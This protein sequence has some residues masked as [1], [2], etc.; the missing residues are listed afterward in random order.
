MIDFTA[1]IAIDFVWCRILSCVVFMVS[2]NFLKV[3]KSNSSGNLGFLCS[4]FCLKKSFFSLS[5]GAYNYVYSH[6]SQQKGMMKNRV[7]MDMLELSIKSSFIQPCTVICLFS[8]P[9]VLKVAV[10]PPFQFPKLPWCPFETCKF[11]V[12]PWIFKKIISYCQS[13][14]LKTACPFKSLI[15]GL[16]TLILSFKD[17]LLM[18]FQYN[19]VSSLV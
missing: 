10:V 5:V 9:Y 7:L 2:P 13:A 1:K 12:V 19:T 16:L 4:R 8:Q 15:R 14:P 18:P 11:A 17:T 3:L 6:D